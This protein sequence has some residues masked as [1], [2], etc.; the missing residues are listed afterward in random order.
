MKNALHLLL[1][2]LV[3]LTIQ[4][5]GTDRNASQPKLVIPTGHTGVITELQVSKNERLLSS[6]GYQEGLSKLWDIQTGKQLEL[7]SSIGQIGHY[8]SY[9][10]LPNG[11]YLSVSSL[12]G[13]DVLE[14][15]SNKRVLH[16][17][18]S[19]FSTYS[20]DKSQLIV[21]QK[22][23][24]KFKIY[25][26]ENFE[27]VGEITDLPEDLY[28]AS[29]T[30]SALD[31][32]HNLLFLNHSKYIEDDKENPFEQYISIVDLNTNSVTDFPI[33]GSSVD[34]EQLFG[35]GIISDLLITQQKLVQE[36]TST[37]YRMYNKTT[38]QKV[39]ELV[40]DRFTQKEGITA[41]ERYLWYTYDASYGWEPRLTVVIYDLQT[42]ETI[43]TINLEDYKYYNEEFTS[44]YFSLEDW[45]AFDPAYKFHDEA[46]VNYL[47]CPDIPDL[48]NQFRSELFYEIDKGTVVEIKNI[49]TDSLISTIE[50]PNEFR[51]YSAAFLN[52]GANV[53]VAYDNEIALF[54]VLSGRKIRDFESNSEKLTVVRAD[55]LEENV[56]LGTNEG[57]VHIFQKNSNQFKTITIGEAAVS[58]LLVV[59]GVLVCGGENS[60]T[61]WNLSTQEQLLDFS[62]VDENWIG[63]VAEFNMQ[64]VED[65]IFLTTKETY[66]LDDFVTEEHMYDLSTGE[67][68]LSSPDIKSFTSKQVIYKDLDSTYFVWNYQDTAR[69]LAT[70]FK[71]TPFDFWKTDVL[72]VSPDGNYI[73]TVTGNKMQ[74][75]NLAEGRRVKELKFKKLEDYY[76]YQFD[77]KSQTLVFTDVVNAF[78]IDLKTGKLLNSW[79]NISDFKLLH[80]YLVMQNRDDYSKLLVYELASGK[81]IDEIEMKLQAID[82]LA[83]KEL[84]VLKDFNSKAIL[85]YDLKKK[86]VVAKNA[87]ELDFIQ[88][89]NYFFDQPES[90]SITNADANT[91][92]GIL[93]NEMLKFDFFG[94]T[95]GYRL[96]PLGEGQMIIVLPSGFY[97]ATKDAAKML[98]YVTPD[99]KVITFDQL[100]LRYNRPDEVLK[101]IGSSDTVLISSYRKAYE[102]RLRKMGVDTTLFNATYAVPEAH[103]VNRA[104]IPNEL[105]TKKL[106]LQITAWDSTF[107]LD[108]VNIWVNE[109]PLFGNHGIGLKAQKIHSFDTLITIEL[110]PGENRIETSVFNLNQIE[111]YRMPL[112]VNYTDPSG[113]KQDQPKTHFIGIGIDK[114]NEPGHDLSYSVK[115]VRD[116]IESAERKAGRS[117]DDR[118]AVQ[119]ERECVQ[120]AGAEEKVAADEHQ[121]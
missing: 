48:K 14:V 5:Q 51:I 9:Q 115:D 6:Y 65:R 76:Q 40:I 114:F 67:R 28:I 103:F 38:G 13:I 80:D 79:K 68:V 16:I 73:M 21:G 93:G 22:E 120:C 55:S 35:F 92:F 1:Y 46:Q 96:I 59:D 72:K 42:Q 29:T 111:S 24:G 101:A 105:S 44:K 33:N 106:S 84:L 108:R 3:G 47:F 27:L 69:A 109:V 75:W 117:I 32:Q 19:V 61:T 7:N 45:L 89:R 15:G 112:Y 62:E 8:Q 88:E 95:L 97:Q 20:L 74:I 94:G 77:R 87:N 100:D 116:L 2:L 12:D 121:R 98:H 30:F 41:D 25:S 17:E 85:Y 90:K 36:E 37:T 26:T 102:K 10:I 107:L 118:Y 31:A 49:K 64:R 82:Y 99:L 56:V 39:N 50:L 58:D 78:K 11:K 53:I 104:T 60:L 43:E 91:L 34:T 18:D 66:L 71:A 70:Y 81:L 86:E 4:A 54:D 110:S 119:S 113:G 23:Y 83:N 57:R 52:K 63:D